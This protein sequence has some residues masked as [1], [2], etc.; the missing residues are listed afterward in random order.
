LDE[1]DALAAAEIAARHPALR[2]TGL[3]NHRGYSASYASYSA[4]KD[5]ERHRRGVQQTLGFARRLREALGITV[6]HLNLGGGFRVGRPEGFGPYRVTEFPS[7]EDYAGAVAGELR[8]LLGDYGLG[9]P[10]LLLEPG[11]YLVADAVL[12]LA[13]VGFQKIAPGPRGQVKW[14]FLDNATAYHFVRRLSSGF[15]HHVV[16]ARLG[17]G[18]LEPV[19]IAGPACSVDALATEMPLP[20]VERGDVLASLDQGA[21]C[22][23]ITSNFCAIPIPAA[24]L[25]CDGEADLV[26]PRETV[27]EIVDRYRIPERLEAAARQEERAEHLSAR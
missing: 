7:V 5:L 27:Q 3:H 9:E 6:R 15:Y 22:E 4:E 24:V 21:Y 8:Q 20:P 25:A 1:S 14:I 11:G 26:R 19:S 18:E 12:L 23:A 17:E 10:D 16:P 2:L 13:T